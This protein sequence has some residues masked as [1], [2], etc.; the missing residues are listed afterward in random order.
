[1]SSRLSA[2]SLSW[3]DFSD[4]PAPEVKVR[5]W[6]RGLMLV[7]LVLWRR[8][9]AGCA[10]RSRHRRQTK[11]PCSFFENMGVELEGISD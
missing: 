7:S 8:L 2:S 5:S 11:L 6:V 10:D 3:F 9:E 1:M 4:S